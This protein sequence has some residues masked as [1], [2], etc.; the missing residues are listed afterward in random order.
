MANKVSI[1]RKLRMYM[2][3][4]GIFMGFIFPV[5]AHFFVSFKEGMLVFFIIGCILAGI[6]VGVVSYQFVKVILLKPLLKVSEVANDIQSK[7]LTKKIDIVSYDS[8]GDIVDGINYA[9]R[10]LKGFLNETIKVSLLIQEIINKAETRIDQ[11]SP[12]SK[13]EKSIGQVTDISACMQKLSSKIIKVVEDGT[14]SAKSSSQKLLETTD[15]INELSGLMNSLSVNSQQVHNII[16]LINDIAMK[17]NI[18]SLNASIEA[19]RAGVYGK[20]FAV[21]AV[22]VKSLAEIVSHSVDD[23]SNI[24][25]KIQSDINSALSYMEKITNNIGENNNSSIHILSQ[26][27]EIISI[28]NY[29]LDANND[30]HKSVSHLNNAFNEIELAFKQLAENSIELQDIV[31]SFK[32]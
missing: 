7:N 28:T 13:I 27:D 18:L 21:V 31:Q 15:N 8:V 14:D 26:L 17:T 9:V 6:T 10:K 3:L 19:A 1:L 2:I 22:E 5:Y 24:I 11:A 32:Q 30:L 4:F 16:D 25:M 23:I 12:L 29:N 20:S